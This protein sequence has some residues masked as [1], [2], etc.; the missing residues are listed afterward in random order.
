MA[1]NLKRK[2]NAKRKAKQV[3]KTFKHHKKLWIILGSIL[4]V[5]LAVFIGLTIYVNIYYSANSYAKEELKTSDTV[6]VYHQKDYYVFEPKT[7]DTGIIFY[8][9]GKV[10]AIAYAPLLKS[11]ANE[12]ILCIL[13]E[14]P[15][16]LAVLNK[17]AAD[18]IQKKFE[19]EN[20]YMAGHSLGGSMA[21]SYIAKHNK[22]YT[23][24][25]LLAAY[26]LEDLS[27]TDLKVLSIYGEYDGI[28]NKK[29]YEKNLSKLPS[30]YNEFVIRGGCHAF[31]GSYGAQKKDGTP[32]ITNEQQ[33]EETISFI[34]E[35]IGS[36]EMITYKES[37][38]EFSNPDCGF[39]EPVYIKCRT[40]GVSNISNNHLKY[41]ALLHLRIDVSIFSG[42]VN[43]SKDIAFTPAMLNDLDEMFH[44]IDEAS[45]CVIVRFAYD[46]NFNGS[47]D[48]E[49]EIPMMEK[50][51]E[52]L[53]PLFLKYEK[54]ITAVEC[55]LVGPWG[56]M[57][58]SKIANQETYNKLI[59]SY[60]KV[61]PN[62]LHLLVRRPKFLY[63]Y[64]GYTLSTLNEFS[65]QDCRLGVYNDGYL[66]SANDLG[67]YDN[68][69]IEVEWLSKINEECS[70]GGE[71]TIPNSTYNELN[72]AVEEM[73]KLH[74]SYLNLRWNDQVVKRWQEKKYTGS[75]PLY[76]SST[77]FDYIKNHLG[78]RFVLENLIYN[79][80]DNKLNLKLKV[81]NVGFG[82]L[83]KAKNAYIVLQNEKHTYTF[84][85]ENVDTK[86]LNFQIDK[87]G[88]ASGEY[89]IYFL[90]A[91][92]YLDG[93]IRSIRFG[94]QDIWDDTIKGNILLEGYQKE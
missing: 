46:P 49:P 59:D 45:S 21:A 88:I 52:S 13:C 61:L 33:I 6:E 79:E 64:Y 63:S 84:E 53:K 16:R 43:G 90:L 32:T 2:K 77:E 24:L 76:K 39:Y 17:D 29:N 86:H 23:G 74:L 14:M 5:I 81:T 9:G 82:N 54:M 10:D 55:G 4:G 91:D 50:H 27:K 65:V 15:F 71:V 34:M 11:L 26:S 70:Y 30:T 8:P 18:G 7:Y 51:I 38:D 20:W 75:D 47:K 28:L 25:I 58:S 37:I 72:N 57:H 94:N 66:G 19:V 3:S 69:E 62:S 80:D 93:G 12:G 60:L 1:Q 87:K 44:K 67:T 78:Y 89:R 48:M 31:F 40:D 68:R 83:V 56:E 92:D 35:N 36:N 22:E 41:N 85:F 73:Y 42:K